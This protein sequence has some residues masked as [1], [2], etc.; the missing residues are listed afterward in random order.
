MSRLYCGTCGWNY[1]HWK[2]TFYKAIPQK[3]WLEHYAASFDTVEINNSFY[4]LP[5]KCTFE[6]WHCET[7]AG[8]VFAVKASR[9]LTHIKKLKDS[10]EPLH[11]ILENSSGLGKKL[12][13]IL[14]QFPPNWEMDLD[15]LESFLRMLPS[16]MRF[17]FEFRDD[18]WQNERVWSI[19]AGYDASYCIMSS[20]GLP[21]YLKTTTD[22]SYIRMHSGGDEASGNYTDQHL[23]KWAGWVEEMLRRGD[24]YV[25]FN[26]DYN[27]YA[28][29]NALTLR[30]MVAGK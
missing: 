13:P 7:P 1:R 9:Y 15:R 11:N 18:S 12:G 28:V 22:F 6:K 10:W 24:V 3:M 14:F 20:P 19:L 27:T 16:G 29:Y 2:D 25:Y 5:E 4:R 17:A 30:K 8:F 23:G 26:N 21:L